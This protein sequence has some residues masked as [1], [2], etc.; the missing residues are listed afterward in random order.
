MEAL[1][2]MVIIIGIWIFGWIV[3]RNDDDDFYNSGW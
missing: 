3:I 2:W 1:L